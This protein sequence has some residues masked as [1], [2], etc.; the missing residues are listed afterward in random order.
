M[1]DQ[2]RDAYTDHG[3]VWS[4]I[5]DEYTEALNASFENAQAVSF[6]ASLAQNGTA[7]ELG[8]GNG[9]IALPLSQTGA[10]VHGLDNSE[11][12]LAALRAK[13]GA[14]LVTAHFGDMSDFNLGVQYDLVY[15][16]NNTFSL[17]LTA[18]QQVGC[19]QSVVNCL[20][21]GG[22]FIVHLNYPYTSNMSDAGIRTDQRTTVMYVDERSA[23]VRFAKHDRNQQLF[24]SQDLW[25]TP[26]GTRTLP[27]KIRYVYPTELDLIATI[28]G[29][30][31]L[32]R[33]GDW[34]KRP[35]DNAC[36]RYTSVFRKRS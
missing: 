16:V 7:L 34:Q 36:W 8:V 17:M 35:F 27:L 4:D 22:K 32:D 1:N 13:K 19:F 11:K 21:P 29:L 33:Y 14:D 30:E 6:L 18:A 31:L 15:C 20:A 24:I 5:Y 25:I 28:S 9:H 23:I 2:A 3:D 10:A 12:M 26:I